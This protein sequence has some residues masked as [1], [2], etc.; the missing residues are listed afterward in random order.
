VNYKLNQ[1]KFGE[2]IKE[3]RYNLGMT[4]LQLAD[5]ICSERHIKN[6]EN[7]RNIPSIELIGLL[8]HKLGDYVYDLVILSKTNIE[9]SHFT[10]LFNMT[11]LYKIHKF[12]QLKELLNQ[13]EADLLRYNSNYITQIIKWY[14]G[15]CYGALDNNYEK[16]KK[17]LVDA[18][19]ISY[20]SLD[21][22]IKSKYITKTEVH[23]L[24]SIASNEFTHKHYKLAL[25]M[26]LDLYTYISSASNSHNNSMFTRICYNISKCYNEL[27]Q[28]TDSIYYSDLGIKNAQTLQ[29]VDMLSESFFEQGQ[30][31]INLGNVPL[32]IKLF[33]KSIYLYEILNLNDIVKA[34]KLELQEKY[35]VN[36]DYDLD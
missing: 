33:K 5:G 4:Q 22:E 31:Y 1:K 18:W 8:S 35:N 26:Y 7:G 23:I 15:I 17:E 12:Q 3:L 6:I 16:C 2:L 32:A 19:H 30:S 36:F 34:R 13:Y 10:I 25:N 27:N 29:S 28:F 24:N 9:N 21:I 20:P 14:K 11:S